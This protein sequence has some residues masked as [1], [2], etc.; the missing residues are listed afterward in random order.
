MTL[1]IGQMWHHNDN[2][3]AFV[4]SHLPHNTIL[5]MSF[6][7]IMVT[8]NW[9]WDACDITNATLVVSVTRL[10]IFRKFFATN[11]LPKVAQIFL[12]TFRL[13]RKI[14][15][16]G[17]TLLWLLLWQLLK[18]W[19]IFYF[20]IWSHCFWHYSAQPPIQRRVTVKRIVKISKEIWLENRSTFF[21]SWAEEDSHFRDFS[22][23]HT[24]LHPFYPR[25]KVNTLTNAKSL[26]SNSYLFCSHTTIPQ[27]QAFF[28]LSLS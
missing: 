3:M 27:P 7:L 22:L 6:I 11:F 12:T 1:I 18:N 24:H 8:S 20:K 28:L 10:G 21:D 13:F 25:Y 5:V 17:W 23:S 4:K 19:A 16:C 2:R 14:T 26:D 15:L 9:L